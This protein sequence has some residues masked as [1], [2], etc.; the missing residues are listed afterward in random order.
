MRMILLALLL[1]LGQGLAFAGDK[2]QVVYHVSDE[3]KV[4]FVL[5]NIQNHIDGVGGPENIEIVLVSHGPAVKQFVD[6]D[7]VDRVRSAV[8]KLQEQGV[9]LEACA[10]TLAAMG[11]EPDELLANFEIAEKGGVTRIAELQGQG[12]AYIR[13]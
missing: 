1:T 6:I 10:N 13:P 11:L 12:Y 4:S 2:P 7:A 3:D 8:T 9:T 5:N